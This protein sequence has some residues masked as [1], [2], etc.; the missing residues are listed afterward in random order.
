MGMKTLTESDE[1]EEE[2]EADEQRGGVQVGKGLD[3]VIEVCNGGG[4]KFVIEQAEGGDDEQEG[5]REGEES[6]GQG[7]AGLI[8]LGVHGVHG[9][10]G[11]LG[12]HGYVQGYAC[13]SFSDGGRAVHEAHISKS[14]YGAPGKSKYR[15]SSLRSE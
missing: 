14:R 15:G 1:G 8:V 2:H 10:R 9:V 3:V 7:F 5:E 11:V 6:V 12:V 13:S 4:C